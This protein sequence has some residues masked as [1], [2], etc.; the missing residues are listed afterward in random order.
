MLPCLFPLIFRKEADELTQPS[1]FTFTEYAAKEE[2]EQI[3]NGLSFDAKLF[4]ANKEVGCTLIPTALRVHL[5]NVISILILDLIAIHAETVIM[6][7]VL[8]IDC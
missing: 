3:S 4:K 7:T 2:E 8:V 5:L 1:Y 6:E